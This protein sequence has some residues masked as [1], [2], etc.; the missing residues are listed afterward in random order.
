LLD[1][2]ARVIHTGQ[3]YDPNLSEVF[4]H[5]LGLPSPDLFLGVGGGP[6]GQQIGEAT[7]ALDGVFAQNEPRAVVVQGDTNSVAAGAL[8]AN[9]REIF[10]CHIEAGLRSHD[11][12]MP[13]EHNRVITDHLSDLC[14]APTTLSV[15]NLAAEG[16]SGRRVV[17]TGNTVVEAVQGLIPPPA[18]RAQIL[19]KYEV[20]ADNYCLSTF[21]RPENVDDPERYATILTELANLPVPVLLP[22]HPR[23]VARADSFG[24]GHLLAKIRVVDPIR[25]R[26]FLA[27]EASSALMISDSGGIAEE[28]SVVK[29]PLV[30]VR[31]STERPEVMGT[32]AVRVKAGPEIGDEARRLLDEGW[33]HLERIPSPY[34][35]GSASRR[36][37][38]ALA[39]RI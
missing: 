22:L 38:E 1:D 14:C 2:A 5:D 18:E 17:L 30:V 35:D 7:M 36:S 37:L 13:E 33:K 39:E 28:A 27:L 19:D 9:S 20:A 15:D 6:R 10:L 32:F 4:F 23:S 34:G 31:N 25:Y 11:R 21:H 16:I 29:R 3:H 12:L 8:A 24:L 26:D